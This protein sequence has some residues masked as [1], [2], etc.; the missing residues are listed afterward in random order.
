MRSRREPIIVE[1]DEGLVPAAS[2]SAHRGISTLMRL[3]TR[4]GSNELV[5]V[6]DLD[7]LE[8]SRLLASDAVPETASSPLPG[9]GVEAPR[10][11]PEMGFLARSQ[12]Q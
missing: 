6:I 3:P 7:P 5:R 10:A 8:L 1:T 9:T 2:V 11:R 12:C 4:P